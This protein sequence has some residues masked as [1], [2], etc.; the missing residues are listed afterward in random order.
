MGPFSE[1]VGLIPGFMS[2]E[3][4]GEGIWSLGV[5]VCACFLSLLSGFGGAKQVIVQVWPLR[6]A[7]NQTTGAAAALLGEIDKSFS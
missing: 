2:V 3:R 1:R 6:H 7:G 4:F 5:C